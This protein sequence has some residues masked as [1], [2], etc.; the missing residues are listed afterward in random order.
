VR[1]WPGWA[2]W[3]EMAFSFSLEFLMAFLFY[4]PLG[5]QFK[6]K[7]SFKFKLNQTCATIQRIFEAQHDATFH[8]SYCFDKINN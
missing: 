4:F 7:P 8:D 3:A 2:S 6:F 1:A 5:F